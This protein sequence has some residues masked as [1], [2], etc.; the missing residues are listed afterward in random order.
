MLNLAGTSREHGDLQH[1]LWIL[2]SITTDQAFI[3]LLRAEV[4]YKRGNIEDAYRLISSETVE[5]PQ[6]E[7]DPVF[8]PGCWIELFQ[9]SS[10]EKSLRL[11]FDLK[12]G[13]HDGTM[14]LAR[15]WISVEPTNMEARVYGIEA[16]LA[17]GSYEDYIRF[18]EVNPEFDLNSFTTQFQF[19]KTENE[20]D[21]GDSDAAIKLTEE[22][23]DMDADSN[24]TSITKVRALLSAGNM[25]EADPQFV[26]CVKD[27]SAGEKL[28][29]INKLGIYRNL[30]KAAISLNRWSEANELS[31]MT[32]DET[33]SNEEIDLLALQSFVGGVEFHN[34]AQGLGISAHEPLKFYGVENLK[35]ELDQLS[36]SLERQKGE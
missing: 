6:I 20:L 28:T 30:I 21:R 8:L 11:A 5:I 2:E 33:N 26:D 36:T 13:Q 32:R 7:Y 27:C 16:S 3:S 31:K 17:C 29:S 1:S 23:I 25:A 4:E 10:P 15:E 12:S 9:S 19:L 14:I 24:Q 18:L 34:S 22:L 35:V